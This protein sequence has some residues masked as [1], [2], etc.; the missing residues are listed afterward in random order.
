MLK[1]RPTNNKFYDYFDRSSDVVVQAAEHFRKGLE[2]FQDGQQLAEDIKG[3]EHQGDDITHETMEML[4]K[5]FITPLERGDIRRLVMAIDDILDTL[6]DAARRIALY[7]LNP[8]LPD[9]RRLAA[10]L[11]N[12]TV[13]VQ[14]AVH[15][16]PHLRKRKG[17]LDHC[18]DVHRCEDEGDRIYHHALA[19]LFKSGLD[20]L[21]IVKWKD[22]IE[23]MENAIDHCQDVA[24]VVAGIVLEHS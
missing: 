18:I 22:I 4:H 21:T 23:D 11:V 8:I 20:P 5:S 10:V 7:E 19:S 1:F 6:D 14:K 13:A 9:V 24:V 15:E 3:F 16:L 2:D 12:G 17:I